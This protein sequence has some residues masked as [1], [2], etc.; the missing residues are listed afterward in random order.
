MDRHAADL[1]ASLPAR[2][3]LALLLAGAAAIALEHVFI[4]SHVRAPLVAIVAGTDYA[5]HQLPA[6]DAHRGLMVWHSLL[7]LLF[8]AIV[9]F[10]LWK[11]FR[12]RHRSL[13]RV[14]GVAFVLAMLALAGSG[15]AI[16]ILMPFGGRSAVVPNAFFGVLICVC[17]HHAVRAAL[18]R[19]Y[20]A[21]RE[22]MLRAVAIGAGIALA[23]VYIALFVNV[24]HLSSQEA[25]GQAFWLGSGTSLLAAE[26]WNNRVRQRGRDAR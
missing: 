24:M 1:T 14:L 5:N 23:R 3:Y 7:G 15:V 25:L 6:F 16:A 17:L 13:H 18:S 26:F 4:P 9:P 19:R 2:A 11:P 22:W 21:H 10:Q 12:A 8:V 20:T